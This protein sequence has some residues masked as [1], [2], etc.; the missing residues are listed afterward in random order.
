MIISSYPHPL[1]PYTLKAVEI[2]LYIS[3]G[4]NTKPVAH[5]P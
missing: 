3:S 4:H 5:L 2:L 1:T